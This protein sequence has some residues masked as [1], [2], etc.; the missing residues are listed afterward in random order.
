M[1][2]V[3]LG[4]NMLV[5]VSPTI[6]RIQIIG[7]ALFLVSF[8][9]PA[10][11]EDGSFLGL[12]GPVGGGGTSATG[13]LR[14]YECVKAC[15]L[16]FYNYFLKSAFSGY[17]SGPIVEALLLGT[18]VLIN[19]LILWYLLASAKWRRRVA[20]L[21]GALILETWIG[22]ALSGLTALYGHFLWVAG[23]LLLMSPE[24]SN[25]ESEGYT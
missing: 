13:I 7:G 20:I 17:S 22:L 8:L 23:I 6:K 10:V 3:C 15:C 5:K 11:R 16:F 12:G 25:W 21:V 19:L 2:T 9:L 18:S 14:G 1:A 4:M 24:V